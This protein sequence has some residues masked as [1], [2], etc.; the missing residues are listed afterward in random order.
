MLK[1][2]SH[3]LPAVTKML[4][5]MLLKTC[6]IWGVQTILNEYNNNQID[7][8]ER[9]NKANKTFFMLQKFLKI[10]MYQKN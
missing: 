7:L 1:R 3:V 2:I 9:I 5:F 10:K 8:Q 4:D 6:K